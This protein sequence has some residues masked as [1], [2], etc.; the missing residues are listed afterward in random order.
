MSSWHNNRVPFVPRRRWT[1]GAPAARDRCPRHPSPSL[2]PC[3]MT[4]RAFVW[5][6]L[7]SG[8]Q[9]WKGRWA[10]CPTPH[11]PASPVCLAQVLPSPCTDQSMDSK[12]PTAAASEELSAQPIVSSL[13]METDTRGGK[14]MAQRFPPP[15]GVAAPRGRPS[16]P[17]G[18]AWRGGT[19]GRVCHARTRVIPAATWS[20]RARVGR[21]PPPFNSGRCGGAAPCALAAAATPTAAGALSGKA[22]QGT[23][24]AVSGRPAAGP[25]RPHHWRAGNGRAAR[26]ARFQ[27]RLPPPAHMQCQSGARALAMEGGRRRLAV[28]VA[29]RQPAGVSA[30]ADRLAGAPRTIAGGGRATPATRAGGT[31]PPWGGLPPA[32]TT[33]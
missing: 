7:L 22:R 30:A 27:R 4:V 9:A 20:G 25:A 23:A 17:R 10:P 12:H 19:K 1:R 13:G 21:P 28:W 18:P 8:P 26:V 16:G 32:A 15:G 5:C 3:F 6:F 31:P 29:G 14:P 33:E 24:E 2:W 11:P